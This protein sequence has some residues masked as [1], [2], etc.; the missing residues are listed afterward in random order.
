M[1]FTIRVTSGQEK[2]LSEILMKKSRAER[3]SIYSIVYVDAV[4]G[5]LFVEGNEENTIVKLIQKVKHVKGLLKKPVSTAELEN[6]IKITKK[7]VLVVEVGDLVEMISGPFK[8]ERAKV[9]QMDEGK[10]EVT[11][12][13]LEV[14]VPIPVTVKGKMV[15]LFQKKGAMEEERRY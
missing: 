11:V 12:E 10:D 13:L 7:P 14:A 6:L 8:G 2:I 5:Y 9:T 15:R 1:I 3:L 4:K